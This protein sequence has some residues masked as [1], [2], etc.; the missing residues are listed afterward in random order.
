MKEQHNLT[1]NFLNELKGLFTSWR[2]LTNTFLNLIKLEFKLARN[3]LIIII[4]ILIA[5]FI[6]GSALWLLINVCLFFFIISLALSMFTAFL[7]TIVMNACVFCAGAMLLIRYS[8]NLT[9]SST[10][11]QLRVFGKFHV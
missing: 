9:F 8:R 5:L 4:F 2:G 6:V 10:R 1:L 11:K 3:S 7:I